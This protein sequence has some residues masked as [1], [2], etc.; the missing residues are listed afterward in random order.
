MRSRIARRHTSARAEALAVAGHSA[1]TDENAADDTR[2]PDAPAALRETDAGE[3]LAALLQLAGSATS[4]HD[5]FV[6][7]DSAGATRFYDELYQRGGADFAPPTGRLFLVDGQPAAMFALVPPAV[8]KRGRL[9][10]ALM[11]ARSSQLRDDPGLGRR[12]QLAASTF[13]QL[14]ETDAYLSRLAVAPSVAGRGVGRTLL[15]RALQ[16]TRQ[17][18]LT[19]CVLEVADT[20]ERAITLYRNAGFDVIGAGAASDPE[21]GGR[22]GYLHMAYTV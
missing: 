2:Q 4:A 6:F 17:L 8:R 18:G 11:L 12:L 21:S 5:V 13:A 20:N 19:R 22:L 9:V 10:G 16:D 1:V 3:H 7:P 15:E 14:R